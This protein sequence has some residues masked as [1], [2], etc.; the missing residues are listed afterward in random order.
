[1]LFQNPRYDFWMRGSCRSLLPSL[2]YDPAVFEHIPAVAHG[3]GIA[4]ILLE[5]EY[6]HPF[7]ASCSSDRKTWPTRRGESPVDGSSRMSSWGST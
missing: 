6:R 4:D 1:M 7:P 3:K 5:K 2:L